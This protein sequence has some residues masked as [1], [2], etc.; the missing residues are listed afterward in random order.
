MLCFCSLS[1]FFF[2]LPRVILY[3]KQFLYRNKKRREKRR[4][5]STQGKKI[6]KEFG[7]PLFCSFSVAFLSNPSF[8]LS[9]FSHSWLAV[10]FF[11]LLQFAT[12]LLRFPLTLC[13]YFFELASGSFVL[14][15]AV[16]YIHDH[17][18]PLKVQLNPLQNG[19]RQAVSVIETTGCILIFQLS[20]D[21]ISCLFSECFVLYPS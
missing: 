15:M 17:A 21:L 9:L 6:K 20:T 1:C 5:K 11:V 16:L 10:T 4:K 2:S 19:D 18:E 8:V 12:Y 7:C 13:K 14:F 3:P